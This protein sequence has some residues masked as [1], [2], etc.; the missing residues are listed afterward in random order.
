VKITGENKMVSLKSREMN[1]RS[2]LSI[3]FLINAFGLIFTL[4]IQK[5]FK[6]SLKSE[7]RK[8]MERDGL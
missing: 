8:V 1:S 3:G 7:T 6:L 4:L 5:A 2:K